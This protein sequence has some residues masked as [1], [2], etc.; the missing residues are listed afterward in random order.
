MRL[1]PFFC[2]LL[3]LAGTAIAQDTNFPVGPQYLITTSSS[4]MLHPIATPSLSLGEAL[5]PPPVVNAVE[6]SSYETVPASAPSETFLG[7]VYWGEHKPSEIIGR[8]LDTPSMTAGETAWYMNAVANQTPVPPKAT[9]TTAETATG[10]GLIEI[11]SAE[12]PPALPAGFIDVGVTGMTDAESLR[13]RGFGQPLGDSAA[14]W[15]THK[16][17]AV[18]T[19]T[20]RDIQRLH[21]G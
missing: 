19:F 18:R 11:T 6:T 3:V 2:L 14:Y 1:A 10:S 15:K 9:E 17:H 16:P 7:G 13:E 12:M 20:N 8:R 21:G 4:M 5:P